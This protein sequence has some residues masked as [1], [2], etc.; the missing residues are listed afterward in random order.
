MFNRET[1]HLC[2]ALTR[3]GSFGRQDNEKTKHITT[4]CTNEFKGRAWQNTRN[5]PDEKE[6][7]R[8]TGQIAELVTFCEC[9]SPVK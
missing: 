4:D 2:L 8:E 1:K 5:Q 6:G 7:R 9:A 3:T